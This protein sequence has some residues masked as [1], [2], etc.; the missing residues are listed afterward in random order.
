[1]VDLRVSLH[2]WASGDAV[3]SHWF[4]RGSA[5]SQ[6]QPVPNRLLLPDCADLF[7][8]GSLLPPDGSS[9]LG[10]PGALLALLSW[11]ALASDD[12]LGSRFR[13]GNSAPRDGTVSVYGRARRLGP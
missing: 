9:H 6:Y 13:L 10:N 7:P 11:R 4:D 8:F 5:C 2:W 1:M 12:C 3:R